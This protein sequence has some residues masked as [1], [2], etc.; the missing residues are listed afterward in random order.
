MEQSYCAGNRVNSRGQTGG[1]HRQ[2]ARTRKA[3]SEIGTFIGAMMF[4]VVLAFGLMGIDRVTGNVGGETIPNVAAATQVAEPIE[5]TTEAPATEAQQETETNNSPAPKKTEKV[6][7]KAEEHARIM[8]NVKTA[9]N[10]YEAGFNLE[11]CAEYVKLIQRY[12]DWD[13]AIATAV[14]IGESRCRKDAVNMNDSHNWGDGKVGKGSYGL[15]QLAV[16]W[17][18]VYPGDYYDPATN[19]EVAHKVWARGHSWQPWGAY[20]SGAYKKWL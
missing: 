2:Q 8:A 16:L 19:I 14:M 15:F 13:A 3:K 4:V 18:D 1:R 20:S 17:K 10:G 12:D 9:A 5:E 7:T 6:D 11:L